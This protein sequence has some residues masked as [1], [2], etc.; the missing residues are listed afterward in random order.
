MDLGPQNGFHGV[1]G[2]NA[3]VSVDKVSNHESDGKS[4][5]R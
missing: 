2:M 5:G 1:P 3:L 4:R